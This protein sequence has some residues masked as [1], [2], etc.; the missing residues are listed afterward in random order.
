MELHLPLVQLLA[1][2][3][4]E[5]L[6]RCSGLDVGDL[7]AWGVFGLAGA[8]DAFDPDRGVKFAT[9]ASVRIR[10]AM[11]DELR[12]LSWVPRLERARH[13]RLAAG[14]RCALPP[15]RA[16]IPEMGSLTRPVGTGG[17]NTGGMKPQF[18]ADVVA[19]ER[20]ADPGDASLD[21]D[22]WEQLLAGLSS[23]YGALMR[24]Y[25]Q[26]GLTML[27]LAK[28]AGLSESRVSQMM[29]HAMDLIRRRWTEEELAELMGVS[30]KRSRGNDD[31]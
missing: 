3:L 20:A 23:T 1:G 22:R 21:R 28:R 6:P 13:K 27:E 29:S 8:I 12:L 26:D 15:H 9:F 5:R 25:F 18:V 16:Q 24:G 2:P 7:V 11:I 10:G 31:R 4:H 14:K 17:M 19:D 30:V